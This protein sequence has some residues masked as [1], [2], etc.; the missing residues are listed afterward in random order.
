MKNH[1]QNIAMESK[2]SKEKARKRKETSYIIHGKLFKV[3]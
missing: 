1:F 2:I 3:K